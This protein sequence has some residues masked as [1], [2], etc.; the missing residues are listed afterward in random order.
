MGK[1]LAPSEKHLEDW[2]VA[3]PEKVLP[4]S[5]WSLRD[6]AT[7]SAIGTILARQPRLPSGRPD[8]ITRTY[9]SIQVVEIKRGPIQSETITQCLRYMHDI[10]HIA[11]TVEIANIG[12]PAFKYAK[13]YDAIA[14]GIVIGSDLPDENLLIV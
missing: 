9:H 12:N 4:N 2:I 7:E 13:D 6:Y 8:L 1:A 3:N 10:Q 11:M 5:K 14:S